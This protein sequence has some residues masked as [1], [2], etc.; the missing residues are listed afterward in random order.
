MRP[1]DL[2]D[3]VGAVHS[4]RNAQ[5]AWL[6]PV[7]RLAHYTFSRNALRVGIRPFRRAIHPVHLLITVKLFPDALES[8][9]GQPAW[10]IRVLSDLA[11]PFRAVGDAFFFEDAVQPCVRMRDTMLV[12]LLWERHRAIPIRRFVRRA[13]SSFRRT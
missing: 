8:I 4:M 10:A 2:I 1:I 12:L 6:P 3:P 13:L 9:I 7:R 11:S 5:F